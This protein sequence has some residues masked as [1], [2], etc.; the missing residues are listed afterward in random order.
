MALM[1]LDEKTKNDKSVIVYQKTSA[2]Q[3]KRKELS[4][5]AE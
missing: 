2:S 1:T 4:L 5:T 3:G